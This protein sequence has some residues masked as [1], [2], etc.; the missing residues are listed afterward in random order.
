MVIS[1]NEGDSN[2]DPKIRQSLFSGPHRGLCFWESPHVDLHR[3]YYIGS[4]SSRPM[5]E[6][7]MEHEMETGII[8]GF[9]GYSGIRDHTCNYRV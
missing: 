9:I 3:D 5:L 8:L 4:E 1:Q 2:I 6:N 7:R